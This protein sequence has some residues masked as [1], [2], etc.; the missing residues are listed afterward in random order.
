V[1]V[2]FLT[3]NYPRHPA[4]LAGGFLHP[5]ALALQARGLDVRVV[6]PSDAGQGGTDA[7]DGIPVRRVRYGSAKQERLAYTGAM[8]SALRSP[9]GI[10]LL[11]RLWR[12]LRR[13]ARA[14]AAGAPS[15]TPTVVH[16]H[17]WIPGGLASPGELPLVLTLHGTDGAL[18]RR[19]RSA[20]LLARPVLR[21]ARV[22]TAVSASLADAAVRTSPGLSHPVRV[23]PMP[24]DTTGWDWTTG[25]GGILLVSRLT[26]QK[27]AHLAITAAAALYRRGSAVRLTIVGDG[28]E[29]A[30]LERLVGEQKLGEWVR[31][32]GFLPHS[33]V[34]RLLDTADVALQLGVGEGF[35]IAAAEALMCGVPVIACEDGGGLLDIVPRAGPGRVIAPE[36]EALADAVA[37][38][39][40]DPAA[41]AA[42][43]E[44]GSEWRRRLDPAAVAATFHDWY[45]EAARA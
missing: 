35:G 44:L 14:E 7:V 41:P 33:E 6:A 20:R 19:S 30:T 45:R 23:Q 39:L 9:A 25:G 4:D 34:R 5:L 21:H 37:A 40:A 38:I 26:A 16:A 15:P 36:P 32:T 24:V 1:R 17:W 43:R 28:P 29:R 8:Q 27:R 2:V 42:A 3:H 22:V 10:W 18:L 11:S 12:A 31:F 13:G